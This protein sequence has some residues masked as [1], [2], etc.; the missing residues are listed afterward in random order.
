MGRRLFY[1]DHHAFPLPA[2]HRFPVAKYA[3]VRALLAGDGFFTLVPA[4]FAPV[5]AI[6]LA[7][8]PAYVRAFLDGTLEPQVMRRIGFPWSEGLV[9]RTLASVGGTLAA[10]EEALASGF[11]GNLAG[12]TH[13]AF[14]AE[15]SG[16][17]VFND[18]AIAVLGLRAAGRAARAAVVDLDVHQGDG[19]ARIFQND[20]AV[21]TLSLH[22]RHN[23]PFRKE[24]SRIDVD[25][26]DAT[27]DDEYLAALGTVLPRIFDFGPRIVFYQSGVDALEGD[28]LGRLAMTHHG[29]LA[30]DRMVFEACRAAA[31]PVV[32]TLGGGYGDPIARTAEA[33]VGTFR[34]AAE[35][36]R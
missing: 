10:A 16:F 14:R 12:G 4:P 6:E 5:Q 27:G 2:G 33:H 30:R 13:H 1:C 15:G 28:R 9:R 19:T 21:L 24:R 7:H 20:D 34:T 23:F 36:F 25:L 11:G 29:L 22:G 32:I 3:L 8:D 31:V 17:C 35:V 26:P 18:I